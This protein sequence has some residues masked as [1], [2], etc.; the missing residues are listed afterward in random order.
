MCAWNTTTR[1]QA[2]YTATVK[3]MY[4]FY[5][6]VSL[7]LLQMKVV[8]H[9]LYSMG[10]TSYVDSQ[11]QAAVALVVSTQATL[12]WARGWVGMVREGG[13]GW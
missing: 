13:W 8:P 4:M 1:A 5:A 2:V 11:R 6:L 10:N 7:Y 12:I 9:L 3:E